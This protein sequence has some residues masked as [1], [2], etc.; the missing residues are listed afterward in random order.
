MLRLVFSL[1]RMFAVCGDPY[2][3]G[4]VESGVPVA[5]PLA[6]AIASVDGGR[7]EPAPVNRLVISSAVF[8]IRVLLE[9]QRRCFRV[10]IAVAG[11]LGELADHI[12][13]LCYYIPVPPLR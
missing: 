5:C 2:R 8:P 9:Y 3:G 11:A 7:S 13:N 12:P 1:T 6:Y 10:S 4:E